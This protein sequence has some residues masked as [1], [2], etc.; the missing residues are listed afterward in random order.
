MDLKKP[1]RT[2][3]SAVSRL[4]IAAGFTQAQ[5]AHLVGCRPQV[6]SRWELGQSVPRADTVRGVARALGCSMEDL[7]G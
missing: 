6:I 1:R 5:L 2:N 7:L 4:R 3:G